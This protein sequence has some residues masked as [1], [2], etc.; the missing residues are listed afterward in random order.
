[1][2]KNW[3][4]RNLVFALI[5]VICIIAGAVIFLNVV[6][7]HDREIAVPDFRGLT[8][9]E[10]VALADSTG[11]RV[12]V[13]DSV[14]SNRNRGCVKH[15]TPNAG[16][17]VKNGRR[18]LLTVNAVNARKV[19]V[20]NLVGYSLR[21]AVPEVEKRGLL[22]GRLIYRPDMATNNV[23]EQHY[24]GRKVEPGTLLEAESVIDL[25]VGLDDSDN[26]TMVPDLKG[27]D[28]KDAVKIIHDSY[29]NV[30]AVRYDKD[31]RTYEDS[32]DAVVYRQSPE[33][34]EFTVGM[35]TDVT[36]YL[37]KRPDEQQ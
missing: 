23:L 31:I 14:Y 34:S 13:I 3:I 7:Q 25:V 26:V 24:R 37:K 35:G 11:V 28:A 33:P 2:M 36:I 27:F 22:I 20:P 12:E 8:M 5:A 1:M 19:A 10:A 15:H 18:I 29:L 4:V 16:T 32:L 6:T 21:Q 9:A 17:K 30:H